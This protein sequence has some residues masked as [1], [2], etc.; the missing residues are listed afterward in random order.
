VTI[1]TCFWPILVLVV[2]AFLAAPFALVGA[3]SGDWRPRGRR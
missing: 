1:G 2:I 3:M